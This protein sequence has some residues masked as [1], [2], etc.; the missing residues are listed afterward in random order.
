MAARDVA[1]TQASPRFLL[2]GKSWKL[3]IIGW[4]LGY[5]LSPLMHRAALKAAELEGA[6]DEIKV[7]PEELESWLKS[8]APKYDGFNVT[9]PHKEAV[10]RWLKQNGGIPASPPWLDVIGAVNTVKTAEGRLTGANTDDSGFLKSLDV[11]RL[12]GKRVLLIGAGGAAQAIAVSLTWLGHVSALTIWN[13]HVE[14]AAALADKVRGL[15]VPGNPSVKIVGGQKISVA[16]VDLIIQA[17]PAGMKG[18][19]DLRLDYEQLHKGQTVYDIVYEP[20]ETTLIREARKRECR[21]VTGDQMLVG[22]AAAA[23]EIWT[24]VPAARVLAA[25]KKALDEHFAAR[26]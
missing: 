22:Q 2:M 14:R 18:Q 9:M 16:D 4:P 19:P 23:F 5:S 25:M 21:T 20:R 7:R 11:K 13:R 26:V 24:G 1:R 3:G 6:Y 12:K 8:E 10:Y 15:Q 17:T